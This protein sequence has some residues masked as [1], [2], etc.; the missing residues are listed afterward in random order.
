[1]SWDWTPVRYAAVRVLFAVFRTFLASVKVR[2]W[3]WQVNNRQKRRLQSNRVLKIG[4][5]F[6]YGCINSDI[7]NLRRNLQL[8][9]LVNKRRSGVGLHIKYVNSMRVECRHDEAISFLVWISVTAERKSVNV[10]KVF[11]VLVKI[12]GILYLQRSRQWLRTASLFWPEN[13]SVSKIIFW[14]DYFLQMVWAGEPHS[15][16]FYSNILL[17]VILFIHESGTFIDSST[18]KF[19]SS[20]LRSIFFTVALIYYSC[21]QFLFL[22]NFTIIFS[23][24]SVFFTSSLYRV[25]CSP[26]ASIPSTVMQL[27][28]Q[29]R[30]RQAMDN[31][32][33]RPQ[34]E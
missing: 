11:S 20:F 32:L 26:A 22:H 19:V 23:S 17:I 28:S 2:L 4:V 18:H 27:V 12:L 14:K 5:F 9:Y 31:L 7:Y 33:N 13:G 3:G 1:M 15:S 25:T 21:F 10:R 8:V 30:N 6:P 16:P 24:F 29:K 34:R